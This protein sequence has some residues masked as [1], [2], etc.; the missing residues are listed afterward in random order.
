MRRS[1]EDDVLKILREVAG[2]G[3][4][5][6]TNDEISTQLRQQG[7]YGLRDHNR[8][9]VLARRGFLRLEIYHLNWRVIEIDGKRTME[10][11]SGHK[12]Y[13]VI[14][15][16]SAAMDMDEDTRQDALALPPLKSESRHKGGDC[17]DCE[18]KGHVSSAG[19]YTSG[20]MECDGT[21][22]AATPPAVPYSS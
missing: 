20:C 17:P 11:P 22:D 3:G 12:P 13:Q 15:N 1:T 5:C 10:P 2:R 7:L 16:D 9:A 6:P 19:G 8:P 18:G 4:R 21:G 14:E